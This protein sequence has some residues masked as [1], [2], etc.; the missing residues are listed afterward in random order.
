MTL[1]KQA[2]RRG[3]FLL[4]QINRTIHQY[5][6]IR[7]GDRV[8]VAVSG[9]KD[10]LSLLTLLRLRQ[11]RV[12]EHYDLCAIHVQGDARGPDDIPPHPPLAD[13]L[14][15]QGHR[16][17]IAPLDLPP[18][19]PLPLSCHRCT[20][21]RRKTIFQLAAQLDCNVVALAHHAD[22]MAQT[23]L[24]N[25][26][27]GGRLETMFPATDYFDARFRLIRPLALTPEQNV[28]RFAR[29]CD[30][31]PPPADCPRSETSR[32]AL[33]AHVLGLFRRESQHVR[34]NVLRAALRQMG[35]FE[36]F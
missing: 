5:D 13:W 25:L 6:M 10:S 4:K 14:Q 7:E 33:M 22:D 34:A 18:G 29:A 8:A 24:L 11:R 23:A 27:Y 9:G 21:N 28:R 19:E 1:S 30:F 3:Y 17:A 31:P 20:W 2:A 35:M 15:A 12:R 16:F 32:R 26:F 36:G